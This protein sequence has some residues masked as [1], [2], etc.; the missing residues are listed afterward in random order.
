MWCGSSRQIHD[1]Q[2]SRLFLLKLL[3]KT[4][5]IL[6]KHFHPLSGWA[7]CPSC[8]FSLS[9]FDIQGELDALQSYPLTLTKA[10]PSHP[11]P[12]VR[13]RTA[14]GWVSPCRSV[15]PCWLRT[16]GPRD[17]LTGD[18]A[19]GCSSL[20][21]WASWA[22]PSVSSHCLSL[23]RSRFRTLK[24][25]VLIESKFAP[26]PSSALCAQPRPEPQPPERLWGLRLPPP[27]PT[28][29]SSRVWSW[30]DDRRRTG[31]P[32]TWLALLV[33]VSFVLGKICHLVHF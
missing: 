20:A 27:T 4:E 12:G 11:E 25:P 14:P 23:W 30:A 28:S 9:C 24:T 3:E 10:G 17:H 18:V 1:N 7:K 6:S 13:A 16:C 15:F 33:G 21:L 2:R 26:C 22:T 5:T 32:L 19:L 29:A 31:H 8:H